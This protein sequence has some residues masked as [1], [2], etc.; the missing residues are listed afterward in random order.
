MGCSV[1]PWIA[2]SDDDARL[3]LRE[4]TDAAATVGAIT[5]N[6]FELNEIASTDAFARHLSKCVC[7]DVLSFAI[8]RFR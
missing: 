6:A 4:T 5:S 1:R 2:P 8:L 7:G 3:R